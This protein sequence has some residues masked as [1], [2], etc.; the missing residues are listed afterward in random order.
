MEDLLGIGQLARASGLT[1][2]ALR[3]YDT[4]AVLSPAAVDVRTGYRLYVAEQVKV[5]RLVARLRRISMPLADVRQVLAHRHDPDRVQDLLCAHLA[6]LEQG[7]TKAR[8]ELSTIQD[9]LDSQELSMVPTTAT[10]LTV[11]GMNLA[12][13][14]HAVR[15]ATGSDAEVPPLRGVLFD[16]TAEAVTLVATDRY[17]LA[18]ASVPVEVLDGPERSAVVPAQLADTLAALG[19]HSVHLTFTAEMVTAYAG[20]VRNVEGELIGDTYPEY[21]RLLPDP[22]TPAAFPIT[23]QLRSAL[24]APARQT[25]HRDTDGV[26]FE[27]VVLAMTEDGHLTVA[28]QDDGVGLGVGVNREFLLEAIDAGGEDQLMLSLDGPVTPVVVRSPRSLSLLMP[29]RV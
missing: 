16:I 2:S 28:S 15:F 1:V 8:R 11:A 14:L 4:A 9:L 20:A 5:A 10:T 17:R 25:M 18:V 23:R 27:V 7:L 19:D 13:A 26:I 12:T 6:T 22:N 24:A 29:V 3:F 21:R